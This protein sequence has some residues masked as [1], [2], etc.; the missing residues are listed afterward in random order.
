MR[1]SLLLI[2][3]LLTTACAGTGTSA[4]TVSSTTTATT[5]APSPTTEAAPTT[6]TTT[7]SSTTTSS[8]TTIPVRTGQYIH[9]GKIDVL[10]GSDGA[11]GSGCPVDDSVPDGVWFGWALAWTESEIEF[12]PACYFIGERADEVGASRGLEV[13]NGFLVV[14]DAITTQTLPFA[15]SPVAWRLDDAAELE[16]MKLAAFLESPDIWAPCPSNL[17]GVW[18]YVNDGVVTEIVR[19]YLP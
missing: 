1:T 18:L 9:A 11:L 7:T 14:N 6:S 3:S 15:E 19:Q 5:S 13:T 12:D 16:P 17:C 10:T 2:A 8:T 4:P